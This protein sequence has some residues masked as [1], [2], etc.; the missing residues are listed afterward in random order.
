MNQSKEK[1]SPEVKA[2]IVLETL[3]S[4]ATDTSIAQHYGVHPVTLSRWKGEFERNAARVFGAD[5]ELQHVEQTCASLERRV[6]ELEAE[7][8]LLKDVFKHDIDT[9]TKVRLVNRYKGDFGLN[10]AC[11]AVELPK[12]TYYYR[13]DDAD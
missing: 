4:Q 1:Y 9:D 6:E 7:L 5:D 13:M 3:R 10:R 2:N 8:A 12:S 11:K